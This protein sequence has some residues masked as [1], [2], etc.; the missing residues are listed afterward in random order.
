MGRPRR[1]PTGRI[2]ESPRPRSRTEHA[3]SLALKFSHLAS[4][5][6]CTGA[7]KP[8]DISTWGAYRGS[9]GPGARP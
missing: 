5:T 4:I 9:L 2:E 8:F 6:D 7:E 1:N 3:R